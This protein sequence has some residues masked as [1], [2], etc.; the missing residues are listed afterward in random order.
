MALPLRTDAL[1][2]LEWKRVTSHLASL[3]VFESVR[4]RLSD[5][6]PDLCDEELAYVYAAVEEMRIL[7]TDAKGP[8][9]EPVDTLAFQAP[10]ARGAVL[11]ALGLHNVR[12]LLSLV[13]QAAVFVREQRRLP[14]G[15]TTVP[16]LVDLLASL[17][18]HPK[19]H[20]RLAQSVDAEGNILSG[21]SPELR[22]ARGKLDAARKRM[23]GAL[24]SLLRK[25]SVRDALQDAV[26]M[27][28]DGRYVLP[29]R[30]DRKSDV[31]GTPRGVS[32][33]GSTVFVEPAELGAAQTQIENAETDVQVEEAR[34][35]R[36]LSEAAYAVREPLLASLASLEIFDAIRSRA[37]FAT[38]IDGVRPRF[39]G[40]RSEGAF[41]FHQARH[42]LFVIEGKP[43]VPNDLVLD[44][45]VWVLS[46]PNAGGKTVAMKTAG[47]LTLMSLAGLHVPALEAAVFRYSEVF[48]EMGDRQNISDDLSTFSGHLMQVKGILGNAGP[49]TLVL[50]DEG[51]VGTDPTVGVALARAALESMADSGATVIITTHFSGL[52][53]LADGDPRFQN[54][55]MEFEPHRLKPTYRLQNGVPGQSYALELATRLG[56]GEGLLAAARSYA[57]EEMMRVERLVA[58]LSRQKEELESLR[59][60]QARLTEELASQLAG[61]ERDRAGLASARDSLVEGYRAKL[62]KRLNAFENR[63]EIRER[64]FE[65]AK[66]DLL[67]DL[68]DRAYATESSTATGGPAIGGPAAAQAGS[69]P[70]KQGEEPANTGMAK[71][72]VAGRTRI[73]ADPRAPG[74]KGTPPAS[75]PSNTPGGRVTLSG[76]DALKGLAFPK[77]APGAATAARPTASDLEALAARARRPSKLTPR[78][79]LDEARESLDMLG[80][81]FDAL[82]DRFQED[83]ATLEEMEGDLTGAPGRAAKKAKETLE[84]AR[85]AQ[86]SAARPPSFWKVGA[87]VKTARFRDIGEVVRAADGKGLVECRFGLVKVKVPHP[88][89]LTVQEAARDQAASGTGARAHIAA[90]AIAS[91]R[92]PQ[93]NMQGH[94]PM[95]APPGS[96]SGATPRPGG[97]SPGTRPGEGRRNALSMDIEPTFQHK[98]NTLDVRGKLVDTAIEKV[99]DFLD[100]ATREGITT[101]IVIHGHGT[102]RVKQ[103]VREFLQQCRYDLSWRPGTPGEGSDGATVVSLKD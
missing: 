18:P 70:T 47:V 37:R 42:P 91:A 74:G 20:A 34:V 94:A 75:P 13:E 28:R 39:L 102:G 59:S 53:T 40:E 10:L 36:E 50:L 44:A 41:A 54:G 31:P 58:E 22:A 3:A 33:S 73:G 57:G 101:F 87:K 72:P 90:G 95:S 12:V 8:R 29:V 43:C 48:V 26:W 7:E 19:L 23:E 51:F 89:L 100:R 103:A 11:S 9:L 78:D 65:K 21:A 67:R 84:N 79:L 1:E 64:Q 66:R 80:R 38:A 77:I 45:N 86:A 30:T 24:E 2:R 61:L 56:L 82:E 4:A 63:L 81:S 92:A 14:G 99:E 52:K 5:L 60:E 49:R 32:Q 17:E 76:F 98:G 46:G 69:Q 55:S 93:R 88:E 25:N 68:E 85:K 27:Q 6:E 71:G 35:L 97:S 96:P 83:A 62:Q 16:L 15:N